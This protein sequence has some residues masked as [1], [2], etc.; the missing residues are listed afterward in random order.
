MQ[1][2]YA[3]EEIERGKQWK[4]EQIEKKEKISLSPYKCLKINICFG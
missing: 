2:K 3:I 4:E 1:Q